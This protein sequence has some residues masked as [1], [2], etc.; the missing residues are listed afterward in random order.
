[1]AMELTDLCKKLDVDYL[2]IKNH[3]E[4]A[5]THSSYG[6]EH[7]KDYNERLEYLGDA[8]LELCMSTY[9]YYSYSSQ[10][11]ILTKKRAQAVREEALNI[12]AEKIELNKYLLLGKGEEKTG[13]RF[14]KAIIADAFEAV[15][16]AI[17]ITYDFN[18][19]YS[20]FN[21]LIVPY[22]NEVL[23]IKDYKSIF[24]EEMQSEKRSIKYLIS[25]ETGP[26]ND[27]TFEALVYVDDLIYGNGIGKTKKEAEQNAAKEAL[28]KRAK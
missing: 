4:T 21:K 7:H 14:N 5:L 13:G 25:K 9:L 23:D 6:N 24:Q 11:G 26:A 1:M 15:L 22:L 19:V 8:V 10:E 3:L 20:V 17:Y 2:K 28:L 18:K 12:Y 27:K 16:G